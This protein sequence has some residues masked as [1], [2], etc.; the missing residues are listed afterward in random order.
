MQRTGAFVAVLISSGGGREGRCPFLGDCVRSDNAERIR[1]AHV[2]A[3]LRRTES[4]STVLV[5]TLGKRVS[6]IVRSPIWDYSVATA[7]QI[8]GI[9]FGRPGSW[10]TLNWC[11]LIFA[12]SSIPLIVTAAVSKRLKPSIGPIRCF[13]RRWS[14]STSLLRNLLERTR[15]RFGIFPSASVPEPPDAKPHRHQA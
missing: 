5:Q 4:V 15:T 11:F 1:P 6:G 12:A 14:C 13:T 7:A 10:A 9:V 3:S 2:S 8:A